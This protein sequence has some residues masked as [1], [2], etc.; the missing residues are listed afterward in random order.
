MLLLMIAA[1]ASQY[2][3][4]VN[5]VPQDLAIWLPIIISGGLAAWYS[6]RVQT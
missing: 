4:R 5:W 2:L 3:G 6:D 1:Q